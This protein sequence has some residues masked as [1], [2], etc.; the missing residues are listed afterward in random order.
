[1]AFYLGNV[2]GQGAMFFVLLAI[3]LGIG[4]LGR[5]QHRQLAV[6]VVGVAL[7][8]LLAAAAD[9]GAPSPTAAYLVT[10]VAIWIYQ[11]E[12]KNRPS[13]GYRLGA[14]LAVAWCVLGLLALSASVLIDGITP[15][16]L[17]AWI[18]ALLGLG[19]WAIP[20]RLEWL[21]ESLRGIRHRAG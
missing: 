2:L 10:L 15:S 16:S 7:V 21:R 8:W 9:L 14:W 12:V 3:V 18:F 11:R 19:L 1:M 4:K 13:G 5:F 17:D 20:W 6:Y